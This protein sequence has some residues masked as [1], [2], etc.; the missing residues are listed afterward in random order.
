MRSHL[1]L[2]E[3]LRTGMPVDDVSAGDRVTIERFMRA[4]RQI[5]APRVPDSVAALGAPAPGARLLDVGGAPGTYARAFTAAGWDVTVL[6]RPGALEVTGAGLRASGDRDG[7]GRRHP[8]PPRRR[9][10]RGLPRR[11]GP[12]LQSRDRPGPGARGRGRRYPRRTWRCRRCSATS[13]RRARPS[14]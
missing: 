12:P 9:L 7:R 8:R 6:D 13:A 3:T 10:G 11:R 2:E 5:A 14:A 1:G 4:M